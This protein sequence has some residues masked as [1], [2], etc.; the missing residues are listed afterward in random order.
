MNDSLKSLPA[1]KVFLWIRTKVFTEEKLRIQ[2]SKRGHGLDKA[3]AEN[4]NCDS[5]LFEV[6]LL[7]NECY[8]RGLKSTG[9]MEWA[10][11]LV[12]RAKFNDPYKET[13][14]ENLILTEPHDLSNLGNIIKSRRSIRAWKE[15]D[16]DVDKIIKAIDLAKW[17][18]CSCNRQLWGFLIIR[19][20]DDK[21]FMSM[22]T[23][24]S[25]YKKAPLV[26]V[27]L[28]NISEY[29][30]DEKHY[31]YLDMGAIIQNLLLILHSEGVGACWMGIKKSPD[32][33]EKYEKFRDRFKIDMSK[34]PISIIP[35]GYPEKI[36]NPPARNDTKDLILFG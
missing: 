35:V 11:G 30:E 25:F 15:N 34:I 10:W 36:P 31:A 2:L 1:Y 6:E 9:V 14:I 22:F 18:P 19:N 28:V 29:R 24:Q 4:I 16:L 21:N 8:R 13:E 5:L 27:P 23:N 17:A 26:I 7:L 20:E 32:I 33:F 12:Y 3:I